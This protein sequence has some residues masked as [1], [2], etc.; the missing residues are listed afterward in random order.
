[1]GNQEQAVEDARLIAAVVEFS[2]DAIIGST[3]DGVVTSWNP[4]AA[5]LYGYSC[6]EIVGKSG[7]LLAPEDRASQMSAV[8]VRVR[9]GETVEHLETTLVRKDGTV[10]PV[11][12]TVAP[13]RDED[14]GI[15][16]VCTF[17]RDVTERGRA[18]EV[19]Q[20]MEAIIESSD[21]AVIALTLEGIVTS[22]N[23]AAERLFGYSTEEIIGK[24][25]ETV[26]PKDRPDEMNGILA[27]VKAGEHIDHL[28]TIRVRKDGSVFP[29]SLTVSAICDAAGTIVGTSM[30]S[31]NM[32]ELKH[33]VRYARSLIEATVDPLV[34]ISPEGEITDVNEASIKVTGVPRDELIG[35]DFTQHFTDPDKAHE[36]YRRAFE[37]GSLIDY[38]LTLIHTDGTLTDVLYNASV[39]R[40]FNDNVLGVVAVARDA[41]QLR[42]QQQLSGQL[43]E[44]L[45]SR[46]VIEQA[47]GI[48]AARRGVSIDL[49]YQ[50]IRTRVATTPA[51]GLSLR[52]SFRWG[53]RSEPGEAELGFGR[54]I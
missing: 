9:D 26:T 12:L 18:F 17:H 49:A 43:Q 3:L 1:M 31:R 53:L 8:L 54:N 19:A 23:P 7:L 39:Y 50:R 40:D 42:Q 45:E 44:A 34:T 36:G 21:D 4:A 11:S 5:T 29:V 38:P 51:C 10:V 46:I 30:I 2:N 24:P 13:I 47:K 27:K 6:D 14:G 15:V 28:E 20:R 16:G 32:T 48:I 33:A 52:R 22:W 41:A 25:A 35:T 37:Q